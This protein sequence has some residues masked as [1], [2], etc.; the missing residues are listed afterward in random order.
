MGE[1]LEDHI[2]NEMERPLRAENARLQA[3]V[4]ELEMDVGM[5][6]D[7][8]DSQD[9]ARY[10]FERLYRRTK[11]ERDRYKALAE[12]RGEALVAR[13]RQFSLTLAEEV[14]HGTLKLGFGPDW[15]AKKV[16]LAIDRLLITDTSPAAEALLAQGEALEVALEWRDKLF[17]NPVDEEAWNA[18]VGEDGCLDNEARAALAPGEAE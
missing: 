7:T 11:L 16:Q 10:D 18:L 6:R 15:P 17:A 3:L 13:L 14:T 4:E 5:L 9:I 8:R 12:L 1:T 2:E